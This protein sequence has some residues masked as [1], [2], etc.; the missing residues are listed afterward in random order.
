MFSGVLRTWKVTAYLWPPLAGLGISPRVGSSGRLEVSLENNVR[1]TSPPA[2][3]W[4]V[5][6]RNGPEPERS[7][8]SSSSGSSCIK[9]GTVTTSALAN[10]EQHYCPSCLAV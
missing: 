9:L 10:L 2:Y 5:M 8:L 3:E 1:I 6:W 4:Q 7:L